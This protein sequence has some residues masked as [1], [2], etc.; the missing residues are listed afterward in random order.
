MFIRASHAMASISTK[1]KFEVCGAPISSLGPEMG[2]R[3]RTRRHGITRQNTQAIAARRAVTGES[4]NAHTLLGFEPQ[5]ITRLGLIRLMKRR[6]VRH[7]LVA[8]KLVRRVRV[9]GQQPHRLFG[10]RFLLPC[11]CPR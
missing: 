9:D 1:S 11:L 5:P 7:N 3:S 10:P 2:S 8:P 4:P 6:E